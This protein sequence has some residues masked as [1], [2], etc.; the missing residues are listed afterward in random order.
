VTLRARHLAEGRSWVL[1]L[2]GEADV[3]TMGLLSQELAH[4]FSMHHEDVVVDVG[5]LAF[6]D[7]ASAHLLLTAQRRDLVTVTGATGSVKRVLDLLEAL[8]AQRM[9]RY[10]A[11]GHP[12]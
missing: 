5:N 1:E 12:R 7:V 4:I 10:L 6:C 3:A 9:P 2:S 8:Q 11:G